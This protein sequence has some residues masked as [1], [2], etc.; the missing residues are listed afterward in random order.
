MR[1]IGVVLVMLMLRLSPHAQGLNIDATR[2]SSLPDP[3]GDHYVTLLAA[4]EATYREDYRTAESLFVSVK[5]AAPQHPAGALLQAALIQTEMMDHERFDRVPEFVALLDTAETRARAWTEAHPEDGWG[6]CF[7]GHIYG[8][9]A[10]WK[11]RN[12]SWFAGMKLG[13]KAKGAYHDALERDSTCWDA[14][15]GLGNYHYWKSA[16]TEFINWTGLFVKDDKNKGE[17]EL[18]LAMER[19]YFAQ[20]ASAAALVWVYIDRERFDEATALAQVWRARY[21]EGEA[22]IWGQAQAEFLSEQNDSAL[23]HFDTLK[24]R[25]V[26]EP[27]QSYFNYIEIDW[28]RAQLYLR[29]A[30]TARACAVM[31][32]L[33]SYPVDRD[34]ADRQKDR[35]KDARKFRKKRCGAGR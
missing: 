19:S 31:D 3:L 9:R 34:S 22:F 7:L 27:E 23:A 2:A 32:T 1:F 33:L 17:A 10:M 26:A 13:L 29:A 4:E 20:A 21:P 16:R 18:K 35:L 11:A 14:Y 25:V 28:H 30:D 8:Y 12:G 5:L 24:A 15:V 6:Y